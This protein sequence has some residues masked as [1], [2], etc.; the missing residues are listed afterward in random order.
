MLTESIK[1]KHR[2]PIEAFTAIEVSSLKDGVIVLRREQ[3]AEGDLILI[4]P[5]GAV[6]VRAPPRRARCARSIDVRQRVTH[7]AAACYSVRARL[8]RPVR[9]LHTAVP[10]DRG[11]LPPDAAGDRE[12]VG[13]LPQRQGPDQ[14]HF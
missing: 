4:D 8:P 13:G 2:I 1:F 9:V 5:A 10:P 3:G 7:P 6:V 11:D 12:Q 14:D